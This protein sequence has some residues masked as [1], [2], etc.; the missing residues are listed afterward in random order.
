MERE[1]M[2]RIQNPDEPVKLETNKKE[3]DWDRSKTFNSE[4]ERQKYNV[5][6]NLIFLHKSKWK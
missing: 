6:R 3:I 2:D 4:V 1:Y 5:G